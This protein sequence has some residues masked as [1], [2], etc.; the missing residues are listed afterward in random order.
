ML[1]PVGATDASGPVGVGGGPGGRQDGEAGSGRPGWRCRRGAAQDDAEEAQAG[2]EQGAL[3]AAAQP[4]RS[5]PVAV[6]AAAAPG[7]RHGGLLARSRRA[8]PRRRAPT[9][10]AR[11]GPSRGRSRTRRSS[12]GGASGCSEETA[13]ARRCRIAAMRLAWLVAVEG[14]AA[15]HHLVEHGAEREDVGAR[16][17]RPAF[18]LLGRHVLERAE[19]SCPGARQRSAA[20]GRSS[21]DARRRLPHRSFARPKSSSFAPR[22]RQHHVAGLEVAVDDPCRCAASSASAIST[23]MP[24]RPGR[25]AAGPRASRSRERLALEQLHDQERRRRPR[26]RRRRARRC[27]GARAARS[28]CASRSKRCRARP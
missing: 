28:R 12:A 24:Q 1:A 6:A 25:A 13:A 18:E 9:A 3:T 10:S 23:P 26:G 19:R 5:R 21:A 4:A 2:D 27:A 7:H 16:V 22:L 14:A 17:G 20:V 8:R 11:P 15:G